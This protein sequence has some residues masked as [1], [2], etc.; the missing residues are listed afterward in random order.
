MFETLSL[1]VWD[2]ETWSFSTEVSPPLCEVVGGCTKSQWYFCLQSNVRVYR[3]HHS[4]YNHAPYSRLHNFWN[5][6]QQ[7]LFSSEQGSIDAFISGCTNSD[8]FILFLI[9]FLMQLI[10]W[11]MQTWQNFCHI[12][13]KLHRIL[14]WVCNLIQINP[15]IHTWLFTWS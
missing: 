2:M 7:C 11:L 13:L 8:T 1:D 15:Y 9:S 12:K 6:K 14:G 5:S 10:S 3:Y 4:T